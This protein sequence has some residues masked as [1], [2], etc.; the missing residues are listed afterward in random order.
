[1]STKKPLVGII[2]GSDS[3]LSTMAESA[4]MLDAL[5]VP[6]EMVISSAHRSLPRTLQF[7]RT[8]EKKGLEIIIVGAGMAAHLAGVIAAEVT[9]PVIGI[10][11]ATKTLSG[12]D[13]LYSMVQ[14]PSGVPVGTVSIGK[15][16]AINAAI[17]A[18]QILGNKYPEYK[19]KLQ[20]MKKKMA[21]EV[22]KKDIKL[23]KIGHKKYLEKK[24]K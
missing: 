13:S 17:L 16:G 2:M 4:A 6:H 1:M 14:M 24:V 18:T 19:K 15:A 11:M 5:G 3:D 7:A 12:M 20:S 22:A 23:Q 9:I 10:P 21:Q 8:A